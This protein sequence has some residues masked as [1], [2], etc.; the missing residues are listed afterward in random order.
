M[1]RSVRDTSIQILARLSTNK[2]ESI[3]H[4]DVVPLEQRLSNGNWNRD[5]DE[6]LE[7]RLLERTFKMQHM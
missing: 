2:R 4:V 1:Y 3:F 7:V 6:S 5:H